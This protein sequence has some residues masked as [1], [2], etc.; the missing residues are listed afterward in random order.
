[1]QP[2]REW[3][4]TEVAEVLGEPQHRLIY[5]CEKGVVQPDVQDAEGRGSSRRFSARNLF[6]FAVALRFRDMQIP[7]LA[8]K[9]ILYFLRK[10]EGQASSKNPGFRLPESLRES[11]AADLRFILSD[12]LRFYCILQV[13]GKPIQV[14][15][16]VDLG[17]ISHPDEEVYLL[18]LPKGGQGGQK[19]GRDGEESLPVTQESRSGGQNWELARQEFGQLEGSKHSRV[20]VNLTAIAKDLKL[21]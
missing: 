4:L 2:D 12:G 15:G 13:P 10:F 1:M 21:G 3:T 6:E 9:Q 5:L 20:E 19:S 8:I 11:M 14:F 16:G 17:K 18:N 7:A